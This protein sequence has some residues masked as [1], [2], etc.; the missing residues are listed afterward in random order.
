MAAT[1]DNE[2]Y[3]SRNL[4]LE[5]KLPGFHEMY[6]G[7]NDQPL[8]GKIYVMYHGTT[9]TAAEQIKK[10]GFKQSSHGMLGRGV[11]VSRDIEKAARYPME[12]KSDQVILKLRVNVGRVKK[13]DY[14]NHPLQKTWHEEGYDT[15]WVPPNCGMVKSGLEEDCVWDPKRIKVIDTVRAPGVPPDNGVCEPEEIWS[16]ETSPGFRNR[17]LLSNDSP[18]DGKIHIM[19]HGT[20]FAKA[21]KYIKKGFKQS[22]H[23][24][25]GK[26]IY[27]TRD[28]SK[29]ARYPL[30]DK[31]NQVILELRVNVGRVYKVD[32]R[33]DPMQRT[34]STQYDSA[35]VPA[36][37]GMAKSG[38][39]RDCIWN[40]SR[41]KVVGI[42][43]ASARY[44]HYL[45]TLLAECQI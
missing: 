2:V 30:G 21:K 33:G 25:L 12:D 26:G 8:D 18:V 24:I 15:A 7:S 16:E 19:Y 37:C 32:H 34:W 45:Q 11:Y 42:V 3:E 14:Q 5:E 38:L 23:G 20:T 35:W 39:E 22:M 10:Y 31:T 27:V 6:L 28:E 36:Y 1:S 40:P 29:A 4:W 44:L 43:E 13:I 17:Y 9:R 41:V